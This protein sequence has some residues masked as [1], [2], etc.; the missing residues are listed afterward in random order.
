MVG[1]AL[2]SPLPTALAL[3]RI[4]P[5]S[6]CCFAKLSRANAPVPAKRVPAVNPAA[7]VL[8]RFQSSL[9]NE[10]P[11]EVRG[12]VAARVQSFAGLS[13]V[14]RSGAGSST[15]TGTTSTPAPPRAPSTVGGANG[16]GSATDGSVAT[17]AAQPLAVQLAP[18]QQTQQAPKPPDF[19]LSLPLPL[20]LPS[21]VPQDVIDEVSG[22]SVACMLPIGPAAWHS[23]AV[24]FR[25][26]PAW[27]RNKCSLQDPRSWNGMASSG[28]HE[29]LGRMACAEHA[30]LLA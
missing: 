19:G 30:G 27:H 10:D 21:V 8:V 20:P 26:A 4:T 16:Q 6:L 5:G 24:P 14:A 25:A 22:R 11:D 12:S 18:Q 2:P 3:K 17:R 28:P 9:G 23:R 29:A 1:V 15:S 13:S 7:G